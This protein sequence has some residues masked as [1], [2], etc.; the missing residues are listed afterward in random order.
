MAPVLVKAATAMTI[1]TPCCSTSLVIRR[2]IR[3]RV[4]VVT[5]AVVSTVSGGRDERIPCVAAAMMASSRSSDSHHRPMSC[6][7]PQDRCRDGF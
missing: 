6:W 2:V 3:G 4:V 7:S 5:D 1:P